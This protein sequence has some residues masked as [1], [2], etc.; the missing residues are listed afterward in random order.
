MVAAATA[1]S[2]YNDGRPRRCDDVDN[3]YQAE[4]SYIKE[5]E[6]KERLKNSTTGALYTDRNPAL[7]T[8]G[9]RCFL[10]FFTTGIVSPLFI[11]AELSGRLIDQPSGHRV[12]PVER[13]KCCQFALIMRALIL[14]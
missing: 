7:V 5:E 3:N 6:K 13:P 1:L 11:K 12:M 10:L 8:S 14:H 2:K 9:A 4:A